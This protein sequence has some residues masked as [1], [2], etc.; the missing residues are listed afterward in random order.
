VQTPRDSAF[1]TQALLRRA[2]K[3]DRQ[4]FEELFERH[5][6]RLH[7]WASGRLS[8]RSNGDMDTTDVMQGTAA[9]VFQRRGTF[10]P[11]HEGALQAYLRR[12]VI[13]RIGDAHRRLTRE[14][15]R[16]SLSSDTTKSV[17]RSPLGQ[18]APAEVVTAY[19]R[20]LATLSGPDQEAVVA[21]LELGYSYDQIAVMLG[22]P[23]AD[24]A[25]MAVTRAIVRIAIEMDVGRP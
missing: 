7:R 24:A 25:R 10:E 6:P 13:N 12:A 23:S 15:D 3:G 9:R 14:P 8:P 1:T 5:L 21:R 2:R 4:A 22:R 19:K 20:A 16:V 18:M 17:Q 11:T